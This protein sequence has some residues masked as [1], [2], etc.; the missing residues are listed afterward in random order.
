ML[1]LV[2]EFVTSSLL[3]VKKKKSRISLKMI[4]PTPLECTCAHSNSPSH[5]I[6]LIVCLILG[7]YKGHVHP[8]AQPELHKNNVM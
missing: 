8:G 7:H 4:F 3:F 1:V 2:S 5:L 6:I